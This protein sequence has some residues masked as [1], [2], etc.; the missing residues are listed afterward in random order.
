MKRLSG[1][2]V[3]ATAVFTAA[4]AA[5]PWDGSYTAFRGEYLI[6]SGS[7][8]D[9]AAP[10]P[11]DRKAAFMVQGDA[12]RQL[13]D[14][15]GPDQKDACGTGSGLRIRQKGDLDCVYDKSDKASPYACHFGIDL[16]TGKS[17]YG[18]IC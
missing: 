16:R 9:E 6:Y 12:A 10:T 1:V 15:I 2:I 13:F 3:G 18:S 17:T 7:L 11:A 14:A 4:Y 8:G 5:K